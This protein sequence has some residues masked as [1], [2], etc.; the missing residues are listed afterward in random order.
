MFFII[1]V[2]ASLKRILE[3][4]W[5]SIEKY[6]SDHSHD[7]GKYRDFCCGELY[8]QQNSCDDPTKLLSFLF[9]IDGAPAVKSKT[10]R[11][12]HLAESS[13]PFSGSCC[14]S[15]VLDFRQFNGHFGCIICL[16]PG[17]RVSKG[18]GTVQ[19]YPVYEDTP[20]RRNQA[21]LAE[22][23]KKPLFGVLG[24]SPLHDVLC[25]PDSLILDY[26][27]LVLEGEFQRRLFIWLN[28]QDQ[29]GFLAKQVVPLEE[30]MSKINFPH[31]FNRKLRPFRDFKRWKDREIQN[32]FLHASLPL[33][34]TLLPLAFFYHLSIFVTAIWLLID[35]Q[36]S[37]EDIELARILLVHY[38]RLV[39]P[40][41]GKS[42]QTYT[43][44][45]LQHLPEQVKNFGPLILHSGFVFEAMIS[46]LKRLFHGT[47]CI[48]DQM[49]KNLIIA[50]NTNTFI[51]NSTLSGGNEELCNFARNLAEHNKS[52]TSQQYD[53]ISL[54]GEVKRST[55]LQAS[56]LEALQRRFGSDV[57]VSSIMEASR[58]KKDHQVYHSLAYKRKGKS[59]SYLVQYQS[60]TS[61]DLKYGKIILYMIV[62]GAPLAAVQCF[63]HG[64]RS[65]MS[66]LQ[67]PE[68]ELM[69]TFNDRNLLGK[70]FVSVN[71]SD[72]IDITPCKNIRR[73]CIL[74]P[75]SE[76]AV[77]GYLCPVLKNYEHH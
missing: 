77:L 59:C 30:A 50:Q 10:L 75:C 28:G 56:V 72:E 38:G 61:H 11:L 43:V 69:K 54:I 74:V 35:D 22:A 48:P 67:D 1:P 27:H 5:T 42:E 53:G 70:P 14:Q 19:I 18:K 63:Q 33:L 21:Q 7:E 37:S 4:N 36:I 76:G 44:H 31:D 24:T 12:R 29:N 64:S 39:E 52:S 26:M 45:A 51:E 13:W 32:F 73:R 40:L 65:I 8:Q 57:I 17:E 62:H 41:Y 20:E 68:D 60:E 47:Q 15:F 3:E 49:V 25:I 58:M 16:H 46:H 34:K 55:N 2:I 66:G 6:K 9:H 23:I 71:E